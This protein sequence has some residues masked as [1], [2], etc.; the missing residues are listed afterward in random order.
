MLTFDLSRWREISPYLDQ[1]LDCESEA[2]AA[3]LEKLRAENPRMAGD[4]EALLAEQQALDAA[5]F[6]VADPLG[7]AA[8]MPIAMQVIGSCVVGTLARNFRGL[9]SYLPPRFRSVQ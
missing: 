9:L 7:P 1:A 8:S 6:L 2:R 5:G 3:W 4:I